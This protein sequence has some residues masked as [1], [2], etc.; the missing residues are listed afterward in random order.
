MKKTLIL[1]GPGAGK[2]ERLLSIVEDELSHGTRPD[3]IAFVSFTKK[4]V[5][6]AKFRAVKKFNLSL[7]DLPLFRTLHS[8]CYWHLGLRKSQVM[9]RGDYKKIG[10][11]L[12][13]TITGRF[14]DDEG[15]RD[16]DRIMFLDTLARSTQKTLEEVWHDHPEWDIPWHEVYRFARVLKKYKTDRGLVDFTDM[17]E[18]FVGPIRAEV[19]VIDEAQDLNHL[20]WLVADRAF[21]RGDRMYIGGDD[22]QAIYEWAGA[23][24]ERFLHLGEDN[25][26][27]LPKSYRL[28]QEIFDFSKK[29][30]GQIKGRY[31]KDWGSTGKK[32]LVTFGDDLNL[33][34]KGTW[35]LLARNVCFL[36]YLEEMCLNAGVAYTKR[37][38]YCSI[39]PEDL[40]LIKDYERRRS[41]KGL[42]SS[43]PIWH[44]ADIGLTADRRAYYV[45]IRRNGGSLV[46]PPLI[47]I[48]T[49]HG[50]KGGE[51][52][53]VALMT[54]LTRGTEENIEN[55]VDT[56][57]RVFYVGATRA[58]KTLTILAPT[59]ERAYQFF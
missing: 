41:A 1:G 20:Q 2:T 22:D 38:N 50:V 5:N 37:G 42:V 47:H 11:H 14:T 17:L 40:K 28:P 26:E 16:G 8:L 39:H 6:E 15:M 46:K 25:R 23:D 10:D 9:Q 34:W 33:S 43:D 27:V 53:H 24:I 3:K 54:D 19:A 49:I 32:G 13:V 58:K 48:D 56:E 7:E 51:A 55:H 59:T 30:A 35:Y 36:K 21:D 18:Q 57:N 44:E 12:N 29:I 4:A 45:T 31:P 52:D